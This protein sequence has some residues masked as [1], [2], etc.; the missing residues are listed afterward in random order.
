MCKVRSVK[1]HYP[2]PGPEGGKLIRSVIAGFR[3]AGVR[4]PFTSDILL[5]TSGGADSTALAHLLLKYGRRI[6]APEKIVLLHINHGWRGRASDGDQAFVAK[7]GK[8]FRARVI[9][10]RPAGHRKKGESLEDAARALRQ[11]VFAEE[12]ARLNGAPVVTAHHADDLAETVLWRLLTGA[13]GTHGAGIRARHG[14]EIR[15]LLRIRKAALKCYLK[16]EKQRWREDSTNFEG[17]LLRS[18]LRLDV[19][20]RLER[21]FPRAVE[22]L[23]ALSFQA[24]AGAQDEQAVLSDAFG[25][26]GIRARRPHWEAIAQAGGELH[27]PEGWKLRREAEGRW[28]IER[29]ASNRINIGNDNGS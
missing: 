26:L 29:T 19:M 13:A 22:H 24:R 23:V 17:R 6:A 12:S 2:V 7:L 1:K 4:L 18:K 3:E 16:E 20:P 5:A 27:L 15:P 9:S 11:R 28:V 25:S 8:R 14:V 21:L 10:H